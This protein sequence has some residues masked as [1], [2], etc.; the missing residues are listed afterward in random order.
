MQLKAKVL[1]GLLLL[2]LTACNAIL[3]PPPTPM[4]TPF[5]PDM[6]RPTVTIVPGAFFTPI[7]PTPTF[8]PEPTSTP[9][10]YVVEAG[11]TLLGIALEYGV[12]VD[13]IQKVNGLENA[14]HLS[15]GQTL[16]IP[17]DTIAEELE[18]QI[19][20]PVGT[21]ILPTPTPLPLAISG[22][23][24]Y[25][26]PVGGVW[27]M[28][29]VIN[30][31]DEPVTNIQVYV[32]LV[33][34]EGTALMS[35]I[36]LA[37]ADYLAPG[38]RAPFAVLFNDAIA[39]KAVDARFEL[40]RG[41]FVSQITSNFIPLGVSE[42]DDGM[43]GPQYQVSGRVFN[44]TDVAIKHATVVVILYDAEQRIIGYRQA[45]LNQDT[46]L[47]PGQGQAFRIL[48]TSQIMDDLGS[49][50][51]PSDFRVIAWGTRVG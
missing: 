45:T 4:P 50:S 30:T 2:L 23:G 51:G 29:E 42:V 22:E 48:L 17:L 24:L 28:G 8:T 49:P 25:R 16:I 21:L 27:C 3:T 20:V 12:P 6:Q 37:A 47:A 11:D 13:A 39:L 44:N 26:T 7:P 32:T 35:R 14:N 31:T 18:Q 19:V 1:S 9:I 5:A 43:S 34:P 36:T 46:P 33:D 38:E 40:L 10:V 41:E 15:I